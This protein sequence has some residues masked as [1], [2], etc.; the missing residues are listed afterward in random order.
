M[1][2]VF[3]GV[4]LDAGL[5]TPLSGDIKFSHNNDG[6]TGDVDKVVYIGSTNSAKILQTVVNPGVD[7][8]TLTINDS[9]AGAGTPKPADVK[10][11]LTAAGLDSAVAGDPLNIG[12][13]VAG[14]VAGAVAIYIRG[15]KA[16][17]AGLDITL[18]TNFVDE[19]DV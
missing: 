5:T 10:L 9:D 7:Q 11:A 14:G 15:T 6:S 3:F 8:I 17:G 4:Y 1:A 13:S 16:D 12:V 18:E 2:L 19:S